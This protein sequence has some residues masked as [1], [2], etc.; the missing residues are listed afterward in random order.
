[1]K[2]QTAF[3][4]SSNEAMELME[5]EEE[6][7]KLEAELALKKKKLC[8]RLEEEE[9]RIAKDDIARRKAVAQARMDAAKAE[10]DALQA[11]EDQLEARDEANKNSK[12]ATS[13]AGEEAA[14]D[15]EAARRLMEEE[16]AQPSTP[17]LLPQEQNCQ[18]Q[19][20][21]IAPGGPLAC[22]PL[23]PVNSPLGAARVKVLT[24]ISLESDNSTLGQPAKSSGLPT[25][26]ATWKLGGSH[27]RRPPPAT[28]Q[29][30]GSSGIIM[31]GGISGGSGYSAILPT[32][33][34]TWKLGGT[35]RQAPLDKQE[36][37]VRGPWKAQSYNGGSGNT[38]IL[39]PQGAAWKLGGHSSITSRAYLP[40]QE[41]H[42]LRPP[43]SATDRG[44]QDPFKS[45]KAWWRPA[46][47]GEALPRAKVS[48][49]T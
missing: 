9:R 13:T 21:G 26:G 1:M 39:P 49:P 11:E 4:N 35:V 47:A 33:G 40:N 23:L 44:P 24:D 19:G 32:Q 31:D 42:Q 7:S 16:V 34:S 37:H 46:E 29:R 5:L 30:S 27:Q 28:E 22:P 8:Q 45:N 38:A 6:A 14:A 25:Q 41:H 48:R 3:T 17:D 15:K 10:A 43:A 2:T 20:S 18:Q 12:R 36:P